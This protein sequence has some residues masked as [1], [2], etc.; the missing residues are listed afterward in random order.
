MWEV[1][2]EVIN[3]AKKFVTINAKRTDSITGEIWTYS[4]TAILDSPTQR[5]AVLQQIKD[6]YLAHINR[7]G[8]IDL[9]LSGMEDTAT[10]SLNTWEATL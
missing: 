3:V 2:I 8:Q 10:N 9:I 7:E 4:C 1:F 6:N 5:S